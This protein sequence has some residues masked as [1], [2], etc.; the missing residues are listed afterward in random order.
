M[1]RYLHGMNRTDALEYARM[2]AAY[3]SGA[4]KKVTKEEVK[5]AMQEAFGREEFDK[6][7]LFIQE[8]IEEGREEGREEGIQIGEHS[9]FCSLRLLQI[10]HRVGEIDEASR[11]RVQGLSNHELVELGKA[12]L[13]FSTLDDL[14]KWLNENAAESP[15][16]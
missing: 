9:G 7:A 15:L 2:L 6:S 3:V 1:F 12:L 14:H 4:N 8:W 10:G 13:N 16:G 11:E 5:V